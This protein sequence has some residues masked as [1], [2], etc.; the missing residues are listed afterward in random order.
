[1]KQ[2]R[3]PRR[4][5]SQGTPKSKCIFLGRTTDRDFGTANR[6]SVFT[7]GSRLFKEEKFGKS[8]TSYKLQMIHI[9]LA[10]DL[11]NICG[12]VVVDCCSVMEL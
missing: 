2:E 6:D 1:M 7:E 3:T 4:P 11:N 12:F 5:F 10:A 9:C 8:I